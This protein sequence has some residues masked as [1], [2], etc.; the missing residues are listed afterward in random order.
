M[1]TVIGF[2]M[3]I[4]PEVAKAE[5]DSNALLDVYKFG[6]GFNM[7]NPYRYGFGFKL[8]HI[9][10]RVARMVEDCGYHAASY[11]GTLPPF[12]NDATSFAEMFGLGKHDENTVSL[13]LNSGRMSSWER[14]LPMHPWILPLNLKVRSLFP[15]SLNPLCQ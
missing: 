13:C 7:L 6:S 15:R 9:L 12:R 8:H 14:S 11:S 5:S 10:L 3:R 1:R 4:P 2:A